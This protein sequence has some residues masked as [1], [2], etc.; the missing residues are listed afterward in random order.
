MADIFLRLNCTDNVSAKQNEIVE[1][2]NAGP[3]V[4]FWIYG[5]KGIFCLVRNG[6]D[7][8][9]SIGYVCHVDGDS[10]QETL[11][12]ILTLFHESQ[13]G[14]L[15]KK[16][17]GQY[18]VLIKKGQSIY[19]FSD[20]MGVRNIFYSDD[21][22]AVSSSFSQV[23]DLLQTSSSDLD[24]YKVLEMLAMRH[25]LYPA[26]LGRSTYHRSIKWLLPYEYLAID[27]ANSG[28][29]FGQQKDC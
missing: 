16:L 8:I 10:V 28:F 11:T 6:E 14:E 9:A 17:V 20:F 19:I 12:Q 22:L 13:I 27:M 4:G 18:V 23:E 2:I 26:W 29:K 1:R 7:A 3:K 21:G 24:M 15:K 5:K 25:I